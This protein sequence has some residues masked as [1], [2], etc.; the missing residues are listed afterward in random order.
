MMSTL[1]MKGLKQGD[2]QMTC[3][4]LLIAALFFF[5]SQA[6]PLNQISPTQPPSSVFQKSVTFSIL[7]Q[8]VIHLL[9]MYLTMILCE[10]AINSEDFTLIPDSKFIPNLFNS[11]MF[12]LI[13]HM[14]INNFWINYRGPPYMEDITQNNY[15]FKS[16]QGIYFVFL[17]VIGGQFEPINDFLQLVQL[18]SKDFQVKFLGILIMNSGMNYLIEL[19]SRK[20]E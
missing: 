4:G 3:S 15:L 14:Q 19:I 5:V 12:L 11:A 6:K 9:S 18:P 13:N 20:M 2:T 10:N 8:F 1:Y 17:I 7:G 16:L